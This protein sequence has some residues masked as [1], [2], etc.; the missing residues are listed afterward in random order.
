MPRLNGRR[1]HRGAR[2]PRALGGRVGRAV[3]DHEHVEVGRAAA[4][5]RDRRAYRPGLVVGG[6]DR[7]L[8]AHRGC[9]SRNCNVGHR[10][11]TSGWVAF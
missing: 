8:A 1:E 11:A 7:E 5:L 4:D 2:R 6:H 3:V 10:V 9:Q